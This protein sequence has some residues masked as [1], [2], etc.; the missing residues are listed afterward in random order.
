MCSQ[1]P[2]SDK[3]IENVVLATLHLR[4]FAREPRV[5]KPPAWNEP[6]HPSDGRVAELISCLCIMRSILI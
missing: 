1:T 3:K 6:P 2:H 4:A 5:A